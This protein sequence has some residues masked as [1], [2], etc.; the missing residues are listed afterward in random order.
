MKLI[1]LRLLLF[2]ALILSA[3]FTTFAGT[4]IGKA[5][6][7]ADGDT[8]TVLGTDNT[9]HKIRLNG[10]DAPESNQEFGEASKLTLSD[11]V[12][13]RQVAVVWNRTDRYN[14]ILGTVTVGSFD[15]GLMQLKVGLAWYFR[16][17]ENDIPEVERH[18]YAA[19]ETEA[20]TRRLG[21]WSRSNP[22]APWD[23]RDRKES[24]VADQP[25]ANPAPAPSTRSSAPPSS[26]G[27]SRRAYSVQCSATT[28]RGTQCKRMT[29]SPNGRCWQH[30]GN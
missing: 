4:I 21:L 2:A 27:E 17:Y 23:W 26:I 1:A 15:V 3:P 22:I 24:P 5:I 19:A 16:Q 6:A 7:V 12:L 13:D 8:I 29:L 9:Q 11:L 14:R 25:K 18:L 20:K 28:K 30:G 10:I